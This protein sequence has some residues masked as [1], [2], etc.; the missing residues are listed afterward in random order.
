MSLI[1]NPFIKDRW[2]TASGIAYIVTSSRKVRE[3][4]HSKG[5]SSGANQGPLK[6]TISDNGNR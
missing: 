4:L 5:C 3:E 6:I 1:S 2:K